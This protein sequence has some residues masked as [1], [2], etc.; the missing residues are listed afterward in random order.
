MSFVVYIAT[1]IQSIIKTF[2][3]Q[4]AAESF[5]AGELFRIFSSKRWDEDTIND[6]ACFSEVD[7]ILDE[8]G[9]FVLP[10]TR[11][12]DYIFM[13]SLEEEFGCGDIVSVITRQGA[14]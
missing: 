13:K 7:F 8:N 5:V 4:E 6:S 10:K 12:S 2:Q 9:V 1:T 11:A 14:F 3:S